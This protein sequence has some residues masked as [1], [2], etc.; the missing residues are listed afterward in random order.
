VAVLACSHTGGGRQLPE[1]AC[2]TARVDAT[3]LSRIA[4]RLAAVYRQFT[5]RP[6]RLITAPAPSSSAAH[7]PTVAPSHGTLRHGPDE[8]ERLS[9]TTSSPAEWNALARIVPT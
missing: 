5:F 3:R 4:R 1:I 6:A 2:P 8:G 9:T 7:G